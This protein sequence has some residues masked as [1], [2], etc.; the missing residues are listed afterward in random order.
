MLE[1]T[2][3]PEELIERFKLNKVVLF[4]GA[5]CSRSVGLPDW[6]ELLKGMQSDFD[7]RHLLSTQDKGNLKGWFKDP[8]NYPR[9]AE[10]LEQVAP[11]RYRDYMRRTFD[12][13]QQ[14]RLPKY[15]S[16]LQHFPLNR[17]VTTNFDKVLEQS[18][19]PAWAG[20]TWQD[21]SELARYLRDPSP[22]IFHIHG[23]IDRF[24]SLVHTRQEY[25]AL[26]GPEGHQAREFLKHL[27][28]SYTILVVGYRLGDPV[29]GWVKT[30]LQ[31]D[32]AI[33]P[34]W[35][36]LAPNPQKAEYRDAMTDQQ[37][38]LLSYPL[39]EKKPIDKAHID[40]L[41]SWF[42]LLGQRLD[43]S[44]T[45]ESEA[46]GNTPY[47]QYPGFQEV[48]QAFLAKLPEPAEETRRR[49]YHGE[50]VQ[51][52]LVNAGYTVRRQVVDDILRYLEGGDLRVILLGGAG[53]EGKSTIL[54]QVGVALANK[55][56]RVFHAD[57][58]LAEEDTPFHILR[59]T[60]G[61]V[62]L[63]I[64]QADLYSKVNA[65]LSFAVNRHE[66]VNIVF[67]AR[68]NE[69]QQAQE[70]Y[71]GRNSRYIN[72]VNVGRLG[73]QEALGI[74][75]QLLDSG[76]VQN[77]DIGA[78]SERLLRDSNGFLLAAMLT[79]THGKPLAR[80]L[81]DVVDH[82]A[83]W[84]E[85]MELL[86]ALGC[87]VTLEA[88]E[89]KNGHP[90]F[91][92][93]RLFQEA[94]NV[95]EFD[96]RPLC[97]Q[98][99]GEISLRPHGKQRVETRHPVIAKTLLPILFGGEMPYLDELEIHRRLMRGASH[100]SREYDNPSERKFMTI[101]P[102][103][104]RRRKDYEGARA[105][106]R[107]AT[108]TDPINAFIWHAWAMMEKEQ[109]NIGT[110]DQ[111]Y[112]ARWLFKRGTDADSTDAP[113]WQAWAM[114]EKEQNN[115]GEIDQA[116]SA[117]WLFKQGS[118]TDPD[119]AFVWQAW[120]VLEKEQ[121]N[122]G[123]IDKAYSSRWL[124]KQSTDTNP[125][126]GTC[127]QGWAVL[128][129]E[130]GNIGDIDQA[131]TARWLFKRGIDIDSTSGTCWQGW[132]MLEKD[133]GNVGEVEQLHTARWLFKQGTE[134][135]SDDD[136]LW[137]EWILMERALS[138]FSNALQLV[139]TALYYLPNDDGLQRLERMLSKESQQGNAHE[140]AKEWMAQGEYAKAGT[141]LKDA[142]FDNPQDT[143]LLELLQQWKA[144]CA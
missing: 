29:I 9:I 85:G 25:N 92:S 84:D 138:Q 132:A 109:G 10:R 104:H 32:W 101:L 6:T 117:R 105:L 64:D 95:L 8:K 80:I 87:V 76:V 42:G 56:W 118:E 21:G 110:T 74:A 33:T 140:Q 13:G 97:S 41:D 133:Q 45:E 61:P 83:T 112:T 71:L 135:D 120:A 28:E 68:T 26:E 49:Y 4:V 126:N 31:N 134:A 65:L 37:L 39:D 115:I 69:W 1:N 89:N 103:L 139:R 57:E 102:M 59:T 11:D 94:L 111:A 82:V 43:I 144:Q 20:Q 66:P 60:K 67:S 131:Y 119:D 47:T 121:G 78:L 142:L 40:G 30:R 100:L 75:Q 72:K 93:V 107:I 18:L 106:Y 58:V 70:R 81:E 2:D 53:G 63:L 22:L 35:Y 48:S 55:G 50:P 36:L 88:H 129:K 27:F 122:I 123:D 23:R 130:Q 51:W 91:C 137:R 114:L 38:N 77:E 99:V 125:N 3:L 113:V 127:W 73:R 108:D 19:G 124:F 79:A 136:G 62:T 34:D 86:T 12:S 52:S 128:E 116:Y 96:I 5:G 14:V 24:H 98:L 143:A 7:S 46:E 17:V 54:M 44:F 141:Y 15:L 16:Q 90:Y